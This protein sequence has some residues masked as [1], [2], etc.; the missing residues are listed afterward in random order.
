MLPLKVLPKVE[1]GT[2]KPATLQFVA[3]EAAGKPKF[4]QLKTLK[5][6]QHKD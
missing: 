1:V 2:P 6:S 3:H 4:V 5:F